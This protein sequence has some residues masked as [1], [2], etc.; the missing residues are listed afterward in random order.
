MRFEIIKNKEL[1]NLLLP[2]I[3][4]KYS[5][6]D[7][8]TGG[9][10]DFICIDNLNHEWCYCENGF[11]PFDYESLINYQFKDRSFKLSNLVKLKLI[12]Q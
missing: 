8:N 10:N 7:G 2:T 6:I 4:I 5:Q 1:I 11:E 12:N 9:D 3:N